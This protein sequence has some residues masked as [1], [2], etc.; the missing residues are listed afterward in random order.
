VGV[1]ILNTVYRHDSS[2]M[3][4]YSHSFTTTGATVSRYLTNQCCNKYS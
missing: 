3:L 1:F 2:V 4:I